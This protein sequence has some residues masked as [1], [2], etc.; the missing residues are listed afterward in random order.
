MQRTTIIEQLQRYI[1]Q[2]IL[3]GKDIGL[4]ETTPLLEWGIIS[5]LQMIKLLN[6]ISQEFD[7]DIPP[8]KLIA[9]YFTTISSIASLVVEQMFA[10]S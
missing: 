9:E 1:A 7:V 2:D 6:F 3:R 5:S 8:D 10:R 4:D